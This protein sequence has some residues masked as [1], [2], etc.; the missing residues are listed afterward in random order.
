MP[1]RR[2]ETA[3]H[4][5]GIHNTKMMAPSPAHLHFIDVNHLK[6]FMFRRGCLILHRRATG[7]TESEGDGFGPRVD[8]ADLKE[9]RKAKA[10]GLL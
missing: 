10:S 6:G 7:G 5:E 9:K 4:E 3:R 8:G 2:P 1:H